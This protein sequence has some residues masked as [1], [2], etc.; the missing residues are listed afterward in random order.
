MSFLS[1]YVLSVAGVVLLSVLIELV[2]PEGQM[3]K[4]T[5]SIL[6][7]VVIFVIASPLPKLFKNGINFSS[8]GEVTLDENVLNVIQNQSFSQIK[9]NLEIGLEEQG[10]KNVELTIFGE[11]EGK[12]LKISSIF[13][14]LSNLVLLK[15]DEHIITNEAVED[16]LLKQTGLKRGQVVFYG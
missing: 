5:K 14:D 16:F 8:L 4:Y 1:T 11:S 2:L 6:S 10:F 3:N 15:K 7:L 9:K 13:V 12:S